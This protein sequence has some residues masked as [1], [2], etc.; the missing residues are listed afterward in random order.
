M[1]SRLDWVIQTG[2]VTDG[3]VCG[4]VD[5]GRCKGGS[6][7]MDCFLDE[8]DQLVRF[9]RLKPTDEL[10][11]KDFFV[12]RCGSVASHPHLGLTSQTDEGRSKAFEVTQVNCVERLAV[13][14][15]DVEP[16]QIMFIDTAI[17][18]EAI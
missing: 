6:F 2:H 8:V 5:G 13:G 4:V 17:Y 3:S 18:E 12:A 10:R 9:L 7:V 14:M 16:Q 1:P 11:M 15:L